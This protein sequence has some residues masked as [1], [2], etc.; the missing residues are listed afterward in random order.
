MLKSF[1]SYAREELDRGTAL[2]HMTRHILGLFQGQPG[3][4]RFRRHLS[5]NAHK[6]DAGINVLED[7]ANFIKPDT[8]AMEDLAC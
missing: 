6:T 1:I 2:K 8:L 5:E 7:A 4:K 3:A